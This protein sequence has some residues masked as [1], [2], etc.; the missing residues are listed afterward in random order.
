MFLY[1]AIEQ[2]GKYQLTID[3]SQNTIHAYKNDLHFFANYLVEAYN[4]KPYL[5]DV[6][7]EDIEDYL[8]YLKESR[9]YTSASRKRKLAVFRTFFNFCIKKKYCLNNVAVDVESIKVKYQERL[10]LDEQEV[11][12]I[13]D[14]IGHK[15][16]RLVV[17]TLFFTGLRISECI[18]LK[19]EDV[20]FDRNEI[21]VMNGKGDKERLVPIH[22]KLLPL[23]QDYIEN[24]RPYSRTDNFFSTQTSGKVSAPY[25]NKFISEAVSQLGWSKKISCHTMRHAFASNLVKRNIH[26]VQIQK[27]LGHTSLTTTSIYTHAK[28][29]DLTAAVNQL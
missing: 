11:M 5:T 10:F 4:C 13:V 17:Q 2:F 19:L 7:A 26:V 20:N 24:L 27:L 22:H 3:R 9:D 21:K 29:D 16:I 18:Q 8:N 25:V 14:Q 12:K 15:L 6:T 28:F 1:E 23:L